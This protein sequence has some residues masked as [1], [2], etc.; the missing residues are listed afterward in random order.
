MPNTA[1]A[2]KRLRQ[3]VVRRDRNRS[4]KSALRTQIKKVRKALTDGNVEASKTE[5][6]AAVKKID[7]AAGKDIIHAN[8]AARIKSRLSRAVK[9]LSTGAS[10]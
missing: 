1:S 7:Q 10:A 4:A 3:N 8:R 2:K 9:K 5:F 6:Q